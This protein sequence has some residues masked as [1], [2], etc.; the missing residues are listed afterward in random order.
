M[1]ILIDHQTKIVIQGISGKAGRLHAEA[2]LN[3]GSQI[4]AGVT[5]G[6]GGGEVYGIPLFNTMQR[7][8]RET[9]ATASLVLVPAP[10]AAEAIL[11]AIEHEIELIVCITEG[12]PLRDMGRV[13]AALRGSRSR[14][15]GPNCPGIISPGLAKMGIMPSSIHIPGPIGVLSRSGTLTYEAV[16]Q[17]TRLGLGQSTCIGIGGDPCLGTHF[18]DV[19]DLF[20]ADAATHM[21]LVIGEIGGEEEERVAQW[22]ERHHGKPIVAYI[23]GRHA[24]PERRMGHAGALIT[25]GKGGAQNKIE[26]LQRVGIPV[27]SS[28]E[29]IG[30]EV[31][32]V[33]HAIA[34]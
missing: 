8:Q 32:Q 25:G 19:L 6:K 11:E 30:R 10:Q 28:P 5:P 9:G 31:Q 26:A 2:C 34:R 27:I 1:P 23:A 14:L 7:A 12:I 13:Q 4:V 16:W 22:F 17:L 24:P 20:A 21:M 3:Y 29:V 15:I 18:T 33:Y